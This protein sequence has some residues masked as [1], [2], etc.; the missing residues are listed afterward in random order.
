MFEFGA[1]FVL[2]LFL[3]LL[4]R[5]ISIAINAPDS[6]GRLLAIGITAAITLYAFASIAIVTNLLPITGIPLPF[7]SYGGTAMMMK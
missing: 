1:V 7:I 3:I 4:W 5:G 6:H 2:I